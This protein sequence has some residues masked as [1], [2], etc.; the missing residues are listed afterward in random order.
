MGFEKDLRRIVELLDTKQV[1]L[2]LRITTLVT[3]LAPS[4]VIYRCMSPQRAVSGA[5]VSK[6]KQ[7]P[8][9]QTLLCSATLESE[10]M[11]R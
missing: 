1:Y 8:L 10:G 7:G 11:K 2:Q 4:T 6:G 3:A 9:R 5:P